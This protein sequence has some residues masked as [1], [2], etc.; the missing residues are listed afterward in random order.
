[1]GEPTDDIDKYL[2]GKLSPED[3]HRLEKKALDDAFLSDALEGAESISPTEF[4]KDVSELQ[5]RL[6]VPKAAIFT[7]LRIAAGILVIL[8]TG[9]L[10]YYANQDHQDTVQLATNKSTANSGPE[11]QAIDSSSHTTDSSHMMALAQPKS[12][13]ET[14]A[15]DKSEVEV[16]DTKA[17]T[18]AIDH[19]NE[20]IVAKQT[21]HQTEQLAEDEQ[22][23][24][25]ASA[26]E[27]KALKTT[28]DELASTGAGANQKQIAASA[29]SKSGYPLMVRGKVTSVVEGTPIPGAN[30]KIRG[31]NQETIT[32]IHGRYELPLTAPNATVAFSYPG[33]QSVEVETG[34]KGTIDIQ[35]KEDDAMMSEALVQGLSDDRALKEPTTN[36][37]Q[38]VGG[39]KAYNQYLEDEMRYPP[40]ALKK[41]INGKVTIEFTVNVLG[42][43]TDFTVVKG[44]GF[45][46]EEE[47]IRLIKEGPRWSPSTENNVPFESKVR[48]KLKFDP[49]R[50]GK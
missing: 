7:P 40:E 14:G 44:I 31:T 37:A 24:I 41:K 15:K 10:F 42:Q 38:P 25:S 19:A 39:M 35:M 6:S 36:I 45:G 23:E 22:P 26:Q 9:V 5:S 16:T 33:L 47:A 1:M 2:N 3:S 17:K 50:A 11:P 32:D 49:S 13:K 34:G 28:A 8:G 21:E 18:D 12:A 30:V 46:C 43:P 20:D 48:V 4:H 27:K 29:R